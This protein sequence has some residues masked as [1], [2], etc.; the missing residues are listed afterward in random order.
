[1][2]KL[3]QYICSGVL[4]LSASLIAAPLYAEEAYPSH[5]ITMIVGFPPGGGT[6][7]LAREL[8]TEMSKSLGQSVV[9]ENRGGANGIIGTGVLA[10]AAPDGYTIMMTISS[11]VTNA[12]LYKDLPYQLS[13]FTPVT[14]VAR[15]P[16]V[17]LA[18]PQ[19]ASN[20][21][22][23]LLDLAHSK[24]GT[25]NYGS[26]GLGSTQHLSHELMNLM[27][28]INMVHVPYRGG[29]PAMNDLLA[30]QISMMFL[31]TVQSLPFLTDHRLKALG[32][33]SEKRVKL[34][35]D[36]PAISETIPGYSS[37]VWFGVIAPTGTPEAIVGKLQ[38]TIAEILKTPKMQERINSFGAEPV[39]NTPEEFAALIAGEKE[40]WQDVLREANIQINK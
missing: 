36:V 31:T 20:N 9:V 8:G 1:M 16:F 21:V 19:F 35:P 5:A 27:G 39:G 37:D 18:N 17:L 13:D 23:E 26:P 15:S 32:V 40:K 29:A 2:M 24:P 4:A 28:K 3:K 11:H 6:D 12:L 38:K 30:N 33:S 10:K 22:Q 25:I 14:V 7:I 34:L